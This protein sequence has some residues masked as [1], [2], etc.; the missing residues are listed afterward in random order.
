MPKSGDLVI[1]G[2]VRTPLWRGLRTASGVAAAPRRRTTGSRTKLDHKGLIA[3]EC[4]LRWGALLF[5]THTCGCLGS[6]RIVPVPGG[7]YRIA[8]PFA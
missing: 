1:G 3:R 2:C 4:R 7:E 6:C 8:C 5:Q